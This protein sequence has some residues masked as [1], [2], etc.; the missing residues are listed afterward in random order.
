MNLIQKKPLTELGY[1]FVAAPYLPE[2]KDEYY[3]RNQQWGKSNIYRHLSA[4]EIE[5]LVRNDNT[6]DNWNNISV[7]NEFNPQLVKHCHFFGLVRIGK[8]EPYFLEF[9]NLR[10]PVGLYNSTIASC[11]FGDNVVVHNVNFLSHYL[12]GNEVMICNVNEMATTGHAKFGNGIVKDG[13]PESVR[14]WLELCNE[15]GGRSIMPFD[16]MLPGD[17]W[18]WTRNRDDK[19]LQDQFKSFTEQQFDKKRG[20]YG[21]VGD[22]C[23]IKNVSILKDVMIGTDAY[24]KGA[25][26]I[27]NVTINSSAEATTQ[28]GEG[29]ELVNGIV[30]Y[31]CRVFYGVKAV[32]FIM[33]SHSQLKYGARLINSYLGNNA[34]ISCCEVLNSLIFPAHEQ[35]H[36]NS[37]LCAALIMGQSNMAA[38]ATIGS[39]H[40]SR[41]PDG[42]IIAGRGFWPGLCVSLK[43]NSRFATFTLIAKGNYMAEMDIPFPFSLVINDE[44][45]NCLKIMT[46]YWFLHNMYAL[47]RN[48]WKY[49]DRDK[50]T[51]KTQL[52]EYDYLAPDSVEEMIHAMALMEAA[53]GKAWYLHTATDYSELT[54]MDYRQ[55]GQDL[56]LN[57]PNDVA[58]L[59]ILV[60]GVENSNRE[61]LLLKVHKTYPLF[62][63]LI[64]LYAVKNV[65]QFVE[66]NDIKT[67]EAIHNI[68]L[69]AQRESWHNVG[70]QL[71][72]ASTLHTLKEEIRANKLNSWADLHAKYQEIG[73]Q[74]ATDKLQ[75]AIASLL[76]V[77]EKTIADF[78]IDFFDECLQASI[79]TQ[80]VLTENIQKS[81]AKDYENPFRK[82][83]YENEA[84]MDA[85]VG[86]LDDNSFIKQTKED[87]LV[88]KQKVKT[89]IKLL[90]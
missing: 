77:Q 67:F 68:A 88:Y 41:G 9:H 79:Q 18:L 19:A 3:L 28:I 1:N 40:N 61:V 42:E 53:T 52:I 6:S 2:G 83:T 84:E 60:K 90:A 49:L 8:L 44:Q 38:G 20:Y 80:T 7:T 39:N 87:L 16:G 24:L 57:H 71:M 86:K 17:A 65:M 22:R 26:K 46:G 55:K 85:V 23:V 11:D 36:N 75:H 81:R 31:G 47:A 69:T 12:I 63:A 13:E 82:M 51:D 56:L 74:Y 15:N 4:L 50:R 14:I 43:H 64:V 5:T 29:C 48:S 37:F 21:M 10:L 54:E 33:A 72:P 30:G 32:R 27:K 62:R 58:K 66:T 78:N 45:H 59:K 70:G 35:H 89:L 25:N 73:S 34:T 76:Y